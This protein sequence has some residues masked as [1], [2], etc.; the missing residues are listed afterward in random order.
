MADYTCSEVAPDVWRAAVPWKADTANAYLLTGASEAVLVDTA[1]RE[2]SD[3]QHI[4]DLLGAAGV[5]ARGLMS[6]FFT[7]THIDHVGHLRALEKWLDLTSVL[8]ADEEMTSRWLDP[9]HSRAF[10][11]WLAEHG[12][13]VEMAAEISLVLE[14][15]PEPMPRRP[16]HVVDGYSFSVGRNTW[17]AI[18]TPGHTPGHLCLYRAQDGVLLTGDHVLPNQ[19]PNISVRPGQP[20][21]PLGRYLLSLA[22]L[23]ELDITLVLSGHGEPFSDIGPVVDKQVIRRHRRTAEVLDLVSD[24]PVSAFAVAIG[25]PWRRRSTHFVDLV[26]RQKFLAFGETLA[27]LVALEAR[28][29]IIRVVDGL[30]TRWERGPVS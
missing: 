29:E 10:A 18:H 21:D 13:S 20:Y 5:D 16:R 1:C 6:L 22:R 7:H 30:S 3:W 26:P 24:R 2:S 25:I 28:G 15:G 14:R 9:Q 8:H 11:T 19:S 12:V 4:P 17:K 23:A 27:H